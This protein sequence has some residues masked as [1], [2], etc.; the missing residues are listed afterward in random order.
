LVREE[1]PPTDTALRIARY[2][3][4]TA[5]LWMGMQ[6]QYDLDGAQEELTGELERI[7][8]A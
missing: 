8:P 5:S 6:M 3:G 2:F 7:A 1:P 4:T